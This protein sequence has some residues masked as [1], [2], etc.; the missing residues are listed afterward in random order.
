MEIVHVESSVDYASNCYL[1]VA[2]GEAVLVDPSAP[3]AS[4][5]RELRQHGAEL[6]AILL[7]HGHFDHMLCM[8]EA[9]TVFHVPVMIHEADSTFV[10]D[11]RKNAYTLFFGKEGAYGFVDQ[12]FSDGASFHIGKEEIQ[13]IHTPGHTSGSC[14]FLTGRTLLS[15]DTLFSMG[16]GRTDLYSGN[17]AEMAASLGLL[18]CMDREIILFPGHGPSATLGDALQILGM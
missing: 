13:T 17:D 16:Y 14:C 18:A 8:Q 11:G 5:Q 12:T 9:R 3:V 2:D 1:M 6:K 4:V 7:T 10:N 15:G